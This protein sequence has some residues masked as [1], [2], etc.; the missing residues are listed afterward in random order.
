[1]WRFYTKTNLVLVYKIQANSFVIY[2][3]FHNFI[4]KILRRTEPQQKLTFWQLHDLVVLGNK[5]LGQAGSLSPNYT[6]NTNYLNQI[7]LLDL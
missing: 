1:M 4:I 2:F 6:K 7:K 5:P 3:K